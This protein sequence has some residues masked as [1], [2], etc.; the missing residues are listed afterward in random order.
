MTAKSGLL[1]IES[2]ESLEPK[3]E[4]I[5]PPGSALDLYSIKSLAQDI[6][7]TADG[8]VREWARE[9]LQITNTL[10]EQYQQIAHRWAVKEPANPDQEC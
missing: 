3:A 5:L 8:E 2:S 1:R 9:I 4:E 7:A 6:E 10:I